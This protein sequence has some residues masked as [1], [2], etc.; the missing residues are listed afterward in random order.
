MSQK[1]KP[2]F[3]RFIRHLKDGR[4]KWLVRST[5]ATSE[6]DGRHCKLICDLRKARA[7]RHFL[8]QQR[9]HF[10]QVHSHLRFLLKFMQIM[11]KSDAAPLALYFSSDSQ[12]SP[13]LKRLIFLSL[14]LSKHPPCHFSLSTSN[15]Q[16]WLLP[17]D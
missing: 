9:Q 10:S 3:H 17:A 8:L 11:K 5:C 6:L 12:Q 13:I 14:S 7:K 16:Q 4:P 2:Q 15:C 1:N